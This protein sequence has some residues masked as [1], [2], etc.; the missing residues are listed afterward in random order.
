MP[1]LNAIRFSHIEYNNGHNVITDETLP[2][3]NESSLFRMDNGGGKSVFVQLLL[4][5]YL[6]RRSRNFPHRPFS[7]YFRTSNPSGIL[8]EWTL[9]GDGGY[10]LIGLLVRKKQALLTGKEEDLTDQRLDIYSFISEY[11]NLDDSHSLKALQTIQ[12]EKGIKSYL[13]FAQI[14]KQIDQWMKQAPSSVH[15]YNLNDS[16]QQRNYFQRLQEFGLEQ[17]EWEQ[18]RTF[19]LDES[20][21]SDFTIKNNTSEKLVSQVFLPAIQRKLDRQAGIDKM[22]NFRE[23]LAAYIKRRLDHEQIY[24]QI[25][26]RETILNALMDLQDPANLLVSNY[27]QRAE[28]LQNLDSFQKGLLQGEKELE[29]RIHQTQDDQQAAQDQLDQILI[30]MKSQEYYALLDEI[31]TFEEKEKALQAQLAALE[32]QL[33]TMELSRKRHMLARTHQEMQELQHKKM[34]ILTKIE[35]LEKSNEEIHTDLAKLAKGLIRQ[36]Q[37]RLTTLQKK[38]NTL[39]K[40]IQTHQSNQEAILTKRATYE[41][42]LSNLDR[43]IGGCEKNLEHYQKEEK[44]FVKN[45]KLSI[46]HSLA[47]YEDEELFQN[48]ER[49]T[50][51]QVEDSQN[52]ET[53]LQ[54]EMAQLEQSLE[55]IQDKQAETQREKSELDYSIHALQEAIQKDQ[56]LLRDK[57]ELCHSLGLDQEKAWDNEFLIQALE[58]RISQ[59][60]VDIRASIERVNELKREKRQLET[61]PNPDLTNEMKEV[62]E[63]QN[64]TLATG[65]EYLKKRQMSVKAKQKLITQHPLLPYS[66]VV[67]SA[68]LKTVFDLFE[69]QNLYSSSVLSFMTPENLRKEQAALYL[70]KD[71]HFYFRFNPA[72]LDEEELKHRFSQIQQLEKKEQE[73]QNHLNQEQAFYQKKKYFLENHPLV[74]K[75]VL[76]KKQTLSQLQDKREKLI[77]KENKLKKDWRDQQKKKRNLERQ[78]KD[79]LHQ[80][81]EAQMIHQATL[82]LHTFYLEAVESYHQNEALHQKQQQLISLKEGLDEE[83]KT[84]NYEIQRLN[85]EILDTQNIWEGLQK[86]QESYKPYLKVGISEIKGAF[87]DLEVKFLSLLSSLKNPEIS[88][89]N[90]DLANYDG[91]F[92]KKKAHLKELL[93]TYGMQG[94]EETWKHLKDSEMILLQLERDLVPLQQKQKTLIQEIYTVQKKISVRKNDCDHVLQAIA[95]IRPNAKPKTRQETRLGDLHPE[96][97]ATQKELQNSQQ[98][99]KAL[100]YKADRLH[101]LQRDAKYLLDQNTME[102]LE[103]L[104]FENLADQSL[105]ALQERFNELESS[106]SH[107]QK[108]QKKQIHEIRRSLDEIG[109]TTQKNRDQ[110]LS[111]VVIALKASLE[112]PIEFQTSLEARTTLLHTSLEASK[113]DIKHVDEMERQI[114]FR[115]GEFIFEIENQMEKIDARTT[116][117]LRGHSRKMLDIKL[118]EWNEALYLEKVRAYVHDLIAEIKRFSQQEDAIERVLNKSFQLSSFYNVIIGLRTPKIYIF[119]IEEFQE[120]RI[121]WESAGKTSGAESFLAAFTIVSTLLSYQRYDELDLLSRKDRH[122]VLIMDNPFAKVHS[123]HIIEPLWEMCKAQNIQLIAFSAVENAA[124]LEAFNV[125]YALRLVPRIDMKNHLLVTQIKNNEDRELESRSFHLKVESEDESDEEEEK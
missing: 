112:N 32:K 50:A 99:E 23:G 80:T 79:A 54:E 66:F 40:E 61:G 49:I 29:K 124:I 18:M 88:E 52:K 43:Q 94:Q 76:K 46:D 104:A 87:E 25:A 10:F 100:R 125:I 83:F 12:E 118:P 106:L 59:C 51:K 48:L 107:L 116:I 74:Q 110:D 60:T 89:L 30:E 33:E 102:S 73:T 7:D 8:E 75:E 2:L 38:L 72:L 68:S 78:K 4:S 3:D 91:Q 82:T 122:S 39:Q 98:K 22:N 47:F 62:L 64:I 115:L 1:R 105:D 81:S 19:N 9:D 11:K 103:S 36:S 93:K 92:K 117:S 5:P 41:K 121:P 119:K 58:K 31:A 13:S 45:W 16:S 35:A 27:T 120:T 71:S 77:T 6:S 37:E 108:I 84:L 57:E 28:D 109:E 42:D 20:G 15:L 111:N 26:R 85:K 56:D 95:Q 55:K 65:V 53:Q 101:Q 90:Q 96:L 97:E 21:L 123:S 34:A 67:E 86:K 44:A 114:V 63:S 70:P 17:S 24:K 69:R 113:S 14:K